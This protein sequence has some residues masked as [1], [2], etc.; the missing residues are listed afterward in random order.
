MRGWGIPENTAQNII[1]DY[2]DLVENNN[3]NDNAVRTDT[4][5]H[6]AHSGISEDFSKHF[7]ARSIR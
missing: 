1:N 4:E 5:T 3:N 6:E 7:P 2:E